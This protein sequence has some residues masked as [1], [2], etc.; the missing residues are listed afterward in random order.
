[1]TA[2]RI[3]RGARRRLH[4]A[5]RRGLER[6]VV[7]LGAT[8]RVACQHYWTLR[9]GADSLVAF[10]NYF[11]VLDPEV[12][13]ACEAEL[14]VFDAAGRPVT[15]TTLAV[16]ARGCAQVSVRELLATTGTD[17]AAQEGS[18]ELD[19]RPPG[20]FLHTPVTRRF[21]VS[22][23]RFFMIYRST[24][25]MLT[26]AHCLEKSES[27][28]GL[29]WPLAS[30]LTAQPRRPAA[31]RCKRPITAGELREL[32]AVAVNY[33]ETPRPMHFALRA[34][35]SGAVVAEVR[36]VVAPRGLL[37][38]EHRP[39]RVAPEPFYTLHSDRLPTPNGKPYLWVAYG[40]GPPAMHHA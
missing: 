22:G 33:A 12:R 37:V 35:A 25:G 24:A 40:D 2:T 21:E 4:A 29:P 23:A 3:V 5:W 19:V 17:P 32:R 34:G 11:S 9:D 27:Y 38:L 14:R 20:D 36:R 16:P 10:H 31:W 1:M 15:A 18:L 13:G 39:P 6:S 30:L 8:P 7:M 28:R 26:T